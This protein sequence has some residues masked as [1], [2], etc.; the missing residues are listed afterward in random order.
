MASSSRR[1]SRAN[2][3]AS[4][5]LLAPPPAAPRNSAPDAGARRAPPPPRARAPVPAGPRTSAPVAGARRDPPPPRSRAP[6]AQMPAAPRTSA[7]DT[8][9]RRVPP[10]PRA[11]APAA[12]RRT[13]APVAGTHRAPPPPRTRAPA[14]Q[15]LRPRS[16]CGPQP[17]AVDEEE[18]RGPQLRARFPRGSASLLP[19]LAGLQ[20][21]P[22]TELEPAPMAE[23][24]RSPEQLCLSLT[25]ADLPKDILSEILLLL[26]PKSILRCRAVCKAWCAVTSDR[27]FLLAHHRRQPPR[28]LLTFLRDVDY[29][30][31][32]DDKNRGCGVLCRGCR[33]SQSRVPV[34]CQ[35]SWHRLYGDLLLQLR[36]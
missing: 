32:F 27:D 10:P 7:P 13:S 28:R 11:R 30:W 36:L 21:M 23:F 24:S 14:A 25:V 26:P 12:G 6:A 35:V 18:P 15:P 34:R 33:H 5:P 29:G 19:R 16:T 4:P 9:A 31:E 22:R 3:A 8:G 1:P 20:Q 17:R 2:S